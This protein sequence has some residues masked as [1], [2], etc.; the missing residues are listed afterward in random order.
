MNNKQREIVSECFLNYKE[1]VLEQAKH[2]DDEDYDNWVVHT[3]NQL[4]NA[5]EDMV[6]TQILKHIES[7]LKIELSL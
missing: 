3:E 7:Y 6:R 1:A 5:I 4:E 2:P